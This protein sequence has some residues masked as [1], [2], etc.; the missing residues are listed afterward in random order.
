MQDRPLFDFLTDA[1]TK[2]AKI[3]KNPTQERREKVAAILEGRDAILATVGASI[4]ENETFQEG[5]SGAYS[6]CVAIFQSAK[7]NK[8]RNEEI[9]Q[10]I[11]YNAEM[12][13]DAYND[14]YLDYCEKQR[15]GS[16]GALCALARFLEEN[17]P[18]F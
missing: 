3:A 12:I 4:I 5:Y 2:R 18:P 6:G 17:V 7:T 13:I 11:V 9:D 14:G 8:E 15:N 10:T 1:P 16:L